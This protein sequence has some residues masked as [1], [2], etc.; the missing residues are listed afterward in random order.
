MENKCPFCKEENTFRKVKESKLWIYFSCAAC[1][2]RRKVK[3]VKSL[4]EITKETYE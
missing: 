3:E 4:K 2:F 1:G